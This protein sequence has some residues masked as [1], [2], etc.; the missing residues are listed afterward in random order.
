MTELEE[1]QEL[2]R[3]YLAEAEEVVRTKKFAD[4]IWGFGKH[5]ADHPCHGKLLEDLEAALCAFE[6]RDP[7]SEQ[8]REVLSFIYSAPQENRGIPS[9]YWLL[10]AAHKLT[11]P[12]IGR[13]DP[14]DARALGRRYGAD[15]PRRTRLPA[16]DQV[17][18]ALE[19]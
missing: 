7:S 13:L 2:Y 11:L 17:F 5:P 6:K 16:Q 8:I 14:A 9:I 15:Y 4:G 3:N 10:I 18:A 1:I 19:R 12:L